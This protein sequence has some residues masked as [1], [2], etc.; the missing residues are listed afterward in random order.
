MDVSR[1]EAAGSIVAAAEGGF[2]FRSHEECAALEKTGEAKC[3]VFRKETD[4]PAGFK[5]A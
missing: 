3:L 5:R 1:G 2:I 4:G